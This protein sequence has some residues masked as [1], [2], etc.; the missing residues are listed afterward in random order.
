[1]TFARLVLIGSGILFVM[2]GLAFLID[3]V[4]W[5]EKVEISVASSVAK[6]DIRALYGG[7]DFGIGCFLLYTVWKQ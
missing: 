3:P 5:A 4:G 2:V 6:T 7:M 1:M